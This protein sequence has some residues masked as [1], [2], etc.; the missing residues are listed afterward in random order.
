MLCQKG[1]RSVQNAQQDSI[2]MGARGARQGVA[3]HVLLGRTRR[4][5]AL[6]P[7]ASA[8]GVQQASIGM[9]AGGLR[10]EAVRHEVVFLYIQC[11][12]FLLNQSP[13]PD[14]YFS[15]RCWLRSC[16]CLF[17]F[18]MVLAGRVAS[19]GFPGVRGLGS[20]CISYSS[21]KASASGATSCVGMVQ[22]A[23]ASLYT[24]PQIKK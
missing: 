12:L 14:A 23:A 5:L 4:T 6:R 7:A 21:A 24:P 17:A 11:N 1:V 15:A 13:K 9:S 22:T 19:L 16:V 8:Q 2:G 10:R 20:Y 3:C 18:C